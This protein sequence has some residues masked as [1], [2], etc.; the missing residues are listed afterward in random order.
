MHARERALNVASRE[1]DG[2][3]N[4]DGNNN[5]ND[6]DNDNDCVEREKRP[7]CILYGGRSSMSGHVL[8]FLDPSRDAHKKHTWTLLVE[9]TSSYRRNNV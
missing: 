1:E 7:C 4:G 9:M 2:S 5:D 3:K 8:M 6:N